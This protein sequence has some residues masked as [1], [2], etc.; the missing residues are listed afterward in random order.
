MTSFGVLAG[1]EAI[2][3]SAP[4]SS[5]WPPNHFCFRWVQAVAQMATSQPRNAAW[6]KAC[7]SQ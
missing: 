2:A 1:D 7:N 5:K 6:L 4:T 3:M